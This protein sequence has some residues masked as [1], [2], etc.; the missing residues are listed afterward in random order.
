MSKETRERFIMPALVQGV[1]FALAVMAAVFL[2]SYGL[3]AGLKLP[4]DS[5]DS[6]DQ[7]SSVSL[8]IDHATGC[9]YLKPFF[10]SLTPRVDA[11]GR[12]ICTGEEG[13]KEM[14]DRTEKDGDE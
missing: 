11:T 3:V 4:G 14:L 10:G 6:P 12:Q 2:L 9:H 7:R 5:T 13:E 8:V 1:L